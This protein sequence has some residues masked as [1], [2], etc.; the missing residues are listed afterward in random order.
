MIDEIMGKT[1]SLDRH[2]SNYR[3]PGKEQFHTTSKAYFTPPVN[4]EPVKTFLRIKPPHLSKTETEILQV[5]K[6]Q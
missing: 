1:P 2:A 3:F 5:K 4:L 6:E